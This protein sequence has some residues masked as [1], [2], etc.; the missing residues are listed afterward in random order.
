MV[1]LSTAGSGVARADFVRLPLQGEAN[2]AGYKEWHHFV[3]QRGPLRVLLN[4]SLMNEPDRPHGSRVVPRVVAIVHDDAWIGTVE[5]YPSDAARIGP[6][7]C[8]LAIGDTQLTIGADRYDLSVDVPSRG[9]AG[10]IEL[11]V[12]SRPFAV[13]NQPLGAGRLSWLFVP[14]LLATGW[15]SIGGRTYEFVDDAAY[16]D[17]NWGRFLWGDDF[18]W[19][20]GS[21]LPAADGDPWSFVFMRMTDGKG[22][23]ALSQAL[24]V[25]HGDEPAAMFRD[26]DLQVRTSGLLGRPPDCTLPAPMGIV[27]GGSLSDIPRRVDIEAG[28][29]N[30]RVE[31]SFEPHA[32]ARVARP[33]ETDIDRS[34]V[35]D[36]T[37]G[38]AWATGS[39]RGRRIEFD[40]P[41]VFEFLHG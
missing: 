21:V 30:G 5:R 14:R 26:T 2:P 12:A 34:V 18:G 1:A 15:L 22:H 10:R 32:Y 25:W 38:A 9:I 8:S 33:S 23:R 19:Q 3:V 6:D 27:L 16:H 39:L 36:E 35:L 20:W 28:N 13:H 29:G 40:G 31:M 24:Y 11:V 41:G 37:S 17:H 7:L 4:L